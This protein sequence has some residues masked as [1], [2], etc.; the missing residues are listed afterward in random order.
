MTSALIIPFDDRLHLYEWPGG[1]RSGVDAVSQSRLV[2]L[3]HHSMRTLRHC[4]GAHDGPA[5]FSEHFD[6]I[7]IDVEAVRAPAYGVP[8]IVG[9]VDRVRRADNGTFPFAGTPVHV[10]L[11]HC[12]AGVEYFGKVDFDIVEPVVSGFIHGLQDEHRLVLA[13]DVPVGIAFD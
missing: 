2:G 13:N 5:V 4:F 12:A 8:V 3:E 11:H 6:A 7:D 10:D 1:V 9:S